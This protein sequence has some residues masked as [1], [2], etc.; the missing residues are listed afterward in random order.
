MSGKVLTD[1]EV[2]DG[3]YKYEMCDPER[4]ICVAK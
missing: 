2:G 1:Y 3:E 4:Q